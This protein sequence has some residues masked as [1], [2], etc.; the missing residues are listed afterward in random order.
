[1][2]ELRTLWTQTQHPPLF[3]SANAN[4]V[5]NNNDSV[6][7]ATIMALLW[8]SPAKNKKASTPE[9]NQKTAHGHLL[10]ALGCIFK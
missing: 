9:S 2:Q 5:I 1:M 6:E 4:S 3:G 7:T 10:V 8:S